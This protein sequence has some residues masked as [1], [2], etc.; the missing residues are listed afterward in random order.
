[1]PDKTATLHLVCGKIAS[2]KSTLARRLAAAPATVLIDEDGWLSRLYP[3]EIA[4]LEDYVRCSGRLRDA[5]GGHVEALLRAGLSV[6]LDFPANTIRQ[7]QWMR[8]L[9]EAAGAA[10]RLHYLDVADKV[11]KARL[12]RRNEEGAHA[13]AP[14]EADF[15]LFT[16]H[17]VPPSPEEGFDVKTYDEAMRS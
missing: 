11:C 12:R 5:M 2:G 8:G 6:V 1:M 15:D 7:R 14:S 13:F 3:D 17:F 16:R 9:I 10:H 4:T